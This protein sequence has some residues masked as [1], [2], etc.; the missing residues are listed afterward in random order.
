MDYIDELKDVILKLHG[1][2]ADYLET[3]PVKETFQDQIVWEGEVEV[4][5]IRGHPQATKCYAWAY[6]TDTGRRFLAVL[7]LPPVD[8]PI[9]AVRAAIMSDVKKD[10]QQN[11]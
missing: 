3:V 7:E 10:K 8:S 5:N 9:N 2:K 4:F 11:G 6:Q 1:V